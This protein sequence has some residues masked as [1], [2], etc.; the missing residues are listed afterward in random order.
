MH[1]CGSPAWSREFTA[2]AGRGLPLDNE[3]RW[4]SWHTLLQA[5]LQISGLIDSYSKKWLDDLCD[6]YLELD[7]WTTLK[8]VASFLS[9][10]YRV[11]LET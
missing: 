4:N 11:T 8:E 7:D 1:I 2:L 6:D 10:F 3:T 9:P 5:A